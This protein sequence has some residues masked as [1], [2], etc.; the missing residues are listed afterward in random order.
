MERGTGSGFIH[1]KR[2]ALSRLYYLVGT[3]K[4]KRKIGREEEEG[5]GEE[6]EEKKPRQPKKK[7]PPPL[8]LIDRSLC[9]NRA[10]GTQE[11]KSQGDT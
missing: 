6:G 10:R 8:E 11:D 4:K 9:I 2:G 3:R 7:I 5:G 1:T